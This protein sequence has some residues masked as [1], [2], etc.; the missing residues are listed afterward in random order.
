MG[1][2]TLA[3]L[4]AKA[5][6]QRLIDGDQL[7]NFGELEYAAV[8]KLLKVGEET[9]APAVREV[10]LQELSGN[11]L[12]DLPFSKYSDTLGLKT[13]P[14][15]RLLQ[16]LL[17]AVRAWNPSSASAPAC[18][19]AKA[20]PR[21]RPGEESASEKQAVDRKDEKRPV[22]VSRKRPRVAGLRRGTAKCLTAPPLAPQSSPSAK[23][24]A[25]TQGEAAEEGKLAASASLENARTEGPGME[26]Q[27]SAGSA[28]TA[29]KQKSAESVTEN[30]A[31]INEKEK[32]DGSAPV[33][34]TSKLE[35]AR[36][37]EKEEKS[38]P[39]RGRREAD[40][41][42]K[43]NAAKARAERS[44]MER[45]QGGKAGKPA[46][47]TEE[48]K[49]LI[50]LCGERAGV[51]KKGKE[52]FQEVQRNAETPR[53]G[54]REEAE[55]KKWGRGTARGAKAPV[56]QRDRDATEKAA[57]A[58][59]TAADAQVEKD[60]KK[61]VRGTGQ[62]RESEKKKA[63]PE[64][65]PQ[66]SR[67]EN[68]AGE[69]RMHGTHTTSTERT[70]G[71]AAQVSATS[72]KLK[73]QRGG[74]TEGTEGTENN[75]SKRG[76]VAGR[77]E[78]GTTTK[79]LKAPRSSLAGEKA[80]GG[81]GRGEGNVKKETKSGILNKKADPTKGKRQLDTRPKGTAGGRKGPNR[82]VAGEGILSCSGG[83]K[84]DA[85]EDLASLCCRV[86]C[87]LP[88]ASMRFER[89]PEDLETITHLVV[90]QDQERPT[91]KVLFVLATGG[92][93]VSPQFVKTA[94]AKETWP[95]TPS[96]FEIYH[97]PT[98]LHRKTIPPPLKGKRV[99]VAGVFPRAC[100]SKGTMTK[101][102]LC[103]L[104]QLCGGVLLE[105]SDRVP[106]SPEF[107]V[108]PADFCAK[109]LEKPEK[110]QGR[111]G[112]D[113]EGTAAEPPAPAVSVDVVTVHW[114]VE[115]IRTWKMEPV[116][117]HNHP[118]AGAIRRLFAFSA[119][120][121]REF[122]S[123]TGA[124]K[125]EK[126]EADAE[127]VQVK[128]GEKEAK[129]GQVKE[130]NSGR[131]KEKAVPK[132]SD[133]KSSD[134][135]AEQDDAEK[136]AAPIPGQ[137]RKRGCGQ[138]QEKE[139]KGEK[140]SESRK[141]VKHTP[142]AT[143]RAR[144][145]R[146][147]DQRGT[148]EGR[149]RQ[150]VTIQAQQGSREQAAAEKK[151]GSDRPP[152]A[153]SDGIAGN[154][155]KAKRQESGKRKGIE[156][157]KE[158]KPTGGDAERVIK[159]KTTVKETPERELQQREDE[160]LW[161]KDEEPEG[162]EAPVEGEVRKRRRTTGDN[163]PREVEQSEKAVRGRGAR[164]TEERAEKDDEREEEEES[165]EEDDDEEEEESE[166]DYSCSEQVE[167]ESEDE[168]EDAEESGDD[169][170]ES[171]DDAE[172]SEEETEESEEEEADNDTRFRVR[173]R[174]RKLS[175]NE[176]D[177]KSAA[178]EMKTKQPPAPA[179]SL[180]SKF[181]GR[182][183]S[184]SALC[185]QMKK[186]AQDP[187]GENTEMEHAQTMEEEQTM[188]KAELVLWRGSEGEGERQHE[189]RGVPNPT[190]LSEEEEPESDRTAVRKDRKEEDATVDI[191]KTVSSGGS[192]VAEREATPQEGPRDFP[193]TE[194]A[195]QSGEERA[196]PKE[197]T[198]K[199]AN[200]LS[201]RAS[202][203]RRGLHA[204]EREESRFSNGS[205]D[206]AAEANAA[207]R[208]ENGHEEDWLFAD[209]DGNGSE[210]SDEFELGP[211]QLA[212][213]HLVDFGSSDSE[214]GEEEAEG[215]DGE[216]EAGERTDVE[217]GHGSEGR[218]ALDEEER[219]REFGHDFEAATELSS[220]G[221]KEERP[222]RSPSP[223]PSRGH[224]SLL[225]CASQLQ[226]DKLSESV[227]LFSE[228]LNSQADGELAHAKASQA[229]SPKDT[230][231]RELCEEALWDNDENVRPGICR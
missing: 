124:Q 214:D 27:T 84:K 105:P 43:A 30:E 12:L 131:P 62:T 58:T 187:E 125:E 76:K 174:N 227:A 221:E 157:E 141:A 199:G 35:N 208:E 117:L 165:E 41:V 106:S 133:A 65:D 56:G 26:K 121:P 219:E 198:E 51:Q 194:E 171:G 61:A 87:M 205:G 164:K 32:G 177:G 152:R 74:E 202:E 180:T 18:Q 75:L 95:R 140:A 138:K 161:T 218:S 40:D 186:G 128:E 139:G 85:G 7:S 204:E 104:I 33:A 188:E 100:A 81:G 190:E 136:N 103:R 25:T 98:R 228:S 176:G 172:E 173:K 130:A 55:Q 90:P 20:E 5:L 168:E 28:T 189:G 22:L 64:G 17:A 102:L 185:S 96:A 24:E 67:D 46:P 209:G 14:Q 151:S 19:G 213:F 206:T 155:A 1:D 88:D 42:E 207:G 70:A 94:D 181:G 230:R 112:K 156:K 53:L 71:S 89:N 79:K 101:G 23:A 9:L 60:A 150:K 197:H 137:D 80:K 110:A 50:Y 203:R 31:A 178:K 73:R 99:A 158:Q 77:S 120:P 107:L 163:V 143:G 147:K 15:R 16:Q 68:K 210:C 175:R 170:E 116:E 123:E 220:D 134:R 8:A 231:G 217:E 2:S 44:L 216:E 148:E 29:R 169:A 48:S 142:A 52:T 215:E 37:T 36:K 166:E 229:F 3:P 4:L 146:G 47:K 115:S 72:R 179:A 45:L 93:V 83:T 159:E 132:R 86:C 160:G 226:R 66:H 63:K 6:E 114:I 111:H 21:S 39:A 54:V 153:R 49:R 91:L 184:E 212:H 59:E 69:E 162:G 225:F 144:S 149:T 118:H 10:K 201:D 192:E 113:R 11:D 109:P 193:Q 135:Q 196:A 34:S 57:K 222:S 145:A 223:E 191:A 13:L 108:C 211:S 82:E 224:T 183:A 92:H 182:P 154:A 126:T 78:G 200:A 167:D 119:L 195:T 129:K 127:K 38:S 122:K 97:F